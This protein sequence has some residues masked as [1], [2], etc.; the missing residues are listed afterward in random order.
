MA[1]R[2]GTEPR[3][4]NRDPSSLG[5]FSDEEQLEEQEEPDNRRTEK[6]KRTMRRTGLLA[7]LKMTMMTNLPKVCY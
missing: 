6:S 3:I 7:A 2:S 5:I 4:M 1:D